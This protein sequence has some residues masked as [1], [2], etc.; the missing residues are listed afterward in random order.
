MRQRTINLKKKN[1]LSRVDLSQ[2]DSGKKSTPLI[3]E[4]NKSVWSTFFGR[5]IRSRPWRVRNRIQAKFQ[6]S[7]IF[8]FIREVCLYENSLNKVKLRSS[9]SSSLQNEY[10]SLSLELAKI[11]QFSSSLLKRRNGRRAR[12]P[13]CFYNPGYVTRTDSFPSRRSVWYVYA[14]SRENFGVMVDS[15]LRGGWRTVV[16][17]ELCY[18]F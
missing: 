3:Y 9:S 18:R 7:K 2:G 10:V 4:N 14:R 13:S 6:K 1:H 5:S 8:K 11:N 17:F 15:D 12:T 16:N